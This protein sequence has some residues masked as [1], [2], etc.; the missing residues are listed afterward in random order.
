V[1]AAQQA[2]AHAAL[3]TAEI[4]HRHAA[5]RLTGAERD[6]AR[7]KRELT[8]ARG[9]HSA[10]LATEVVLRHRAAVDRSE[11]VDTAIRAA[12]RDA[13]PA[14]AARQEAASA[15]VRALHAAAAG[16]EGRADT[17]ERRAAGLQDR[18]ESAR[19]AAT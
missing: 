15:L 2:S 4:T 16:A 17:E 11:R 3:V 12:E 9:L 6:A 19:R 10:W 18:G 1:D 7:I 14:L 5:M 8:D 13:A